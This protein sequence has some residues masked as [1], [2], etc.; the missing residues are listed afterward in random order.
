MKRMRRLT[1]RTALSVATIWVLSLASA[2]AFGVGTGHQLSTARVNAEPWQVLSSARTTVEAPGGGAVTFELRRLARA[3]N[4]GRQVVTLL[5]TGRSLEAGGRFLVL[6]NGERLGELRADAAGR[7]ELRVASGG[8]QAGWQP[9]PSEMLQDR[10]LAFVQLVQ[11]SSGGAAGGV[12]YSRSEG[13][14]DGSDGDVY[15]DWTPLCGADPEVFGGAAVY[16]D[17]SIQ[18]LD[19]FAVGLEPGSSFGVVVDGVALG[20]VLVDQEGCLWAEYTTSP[21]DTGSLP[22]PVELTPVDSIDIVQVL[23]E[24]DEVLGGSFRQPCELQL[25][26]PVEWGG[27]DLCPQDADEWAWGF[28]GWDRWDDGHEDAVVAAEGLEPATEVTIVFDGRLVGSALVDD[29]GMLWVTFSSDPQ[30]DDLPLPGDVLPLSSVDRV[31]IEAGGGALLFGSASDPCDGGWEPPVPVESDTTDLCP[32]DPATGAAGMVG[33]ERY[34]DGAEDLW[35]VAFGLVPGA[36]YEVTVD[37]VAIGPA[38]ADDGG[39]LE[40]YLSSDP[41]TMG[42]DP[43]P[44]ALQPVSGVDVVEITSPEGVILAGSFSDPCGEWD[45]EPPVPD[46][47][48]STPLCPSQNGL[49]WGFAAWETFSDPEAEAFLVSAEL[50]EPDAQYELRVDGQVVGTYLTDGNGSLLLDFCSDPGALGCSMPLPAALS[51]VTAIDAVEIVASDGSTVLEGSFSEPC[52]QGG[53]EPPV[54]VDEGET[55]LCD[56]QGGEAWGYANWAVF[57]NPESEAFLLYAEDLEAGAAYTLTVNG[58][59]VGTYTAD[60]WGS[61]LLDFCSDPQLLGCSEVLPPALSPVSAIDTIALLDGT[62][63]PALAGS[64]SQPCD[65]WGGGDGDGDLLRDET[66]LC[67]V[68]TGM[69][70]GAADWYQVVASDGTVIEEGIE[71]FFYGGDPAGTYTVVIDGIVAGT[72]P[73]SPLGIELVLSSSGQ[74]NP[75]PPELSPVSGID[76]IQILDDAGSVVAAGSFSQPCSDGGGGW[77]QW[78]LRRSRVSREAAVRAV[79]R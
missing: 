51:P 49:A 5:A 2:M 10:A 74:P 39:M 11:E 66:G 15:S 79:S 31:S 6:V 56:A 72:V 4:P 52:D 53:W 47:E 24:G 33:W 18:A 16:R 55:T 63:A 1:V 3:G 69:D 54:L 30:G 73:G 64:F 41:E 43:L 13:E 12:L 78:L 50:L 27:F 75:L 70:A 68:T 20:E 9:V 22:L 67:D 61:L 25:P 17:E 46:A 58:G 40:L 28:F 77:A 42:G 21:D 29:W 38:T 62:G 35:I 57:E 76:T 60:G 71:V 45:W 19:I 37:G 23:G 7:A 26:E 59:P 48:G 14:G 36:A 34:E 65:P 44:G 8:F 32:L